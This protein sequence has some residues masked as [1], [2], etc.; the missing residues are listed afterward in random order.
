MRRSLS[1]RSVPVNG[2]NSVLV[3]DNS[4]LRF[5]L[6]DDILTCFHITRHEDAIAM[7]LL[8]CA[9][10]RSFRRRAQA[11]PNHIR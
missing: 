10:L 7:Q 6:L 5:L 11:F 4:I 8:G 3:R 1:A 9:L 2:T